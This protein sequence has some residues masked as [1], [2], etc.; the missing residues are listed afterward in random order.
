MHKFGLTLLLSLASLQ[1]IANVTNNLLQECI[2]KLLPEKVAKFDYTYIQNSTYHSPRPWMVIRTEHRG[3]TWIDEHNF[4]M[5]DTITYSGKNYISNERFTEDTLL[6]VPHGKNKPVEVTKTMLAEELYDIAKFHPAMLLMHFAKQKEQHIKVVVKH[7]IYTQYINGI[8]VILFI[9]KQNH[10]LDKVTVMR[11]EDVYGD[12]KYTINYLQYTRYNNG[13]NYYARQTN[14]QRL[15]PEITDTL[16]FNFLTMQKIAPILIEEVGGYSI[17][18][19]KPNPPD[20]IYREKINNHLY[21]LHLPQA[22]SAAL[23]VEFKDFFVVIDVPMNSKNGELVLQEA[24]KIAPE[25][26]VKYYTFCHH[27]PW[28]I[29][30]VRPFIHRG[31]TVLTQQSNK[32]YLQF[33]ANNPHTIEADSLQINPKPLLIEEVGVTKTITDGSYTMVLYHIGEQSLHTEDYTLFYFPEDK[34]LFQGDMTSIKNNQ[35]LSE[36]G[37][38]QKALYNA[39]KKLNIEVN[40]VIQAWPWNSQYNI[41]TVIPFSELEE[42]VKMSTVK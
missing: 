18:E 22:Q 38:K 16:Y 39:I 2:A 36:A 11:N 4:T 10:L 14:Y 24:R 21:A 8:E 7:H 37:D 15:Q 35:P 6:F 32:Q 12:V 23:L 30:G 34:T 1:V 41:K 40:T 26:P 5:S 9:N 33:I 42:S 27:H 13:K 20:V 3:S 25:K 29:G 19:D 28:Y 17:S 31:A